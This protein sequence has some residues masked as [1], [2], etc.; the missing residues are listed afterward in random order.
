MTPEQFAREARRERAVLALTDPAGEADAVSPLSPA[1][2]WAILLELADE[3]AMR[4][5]V[6]A[7]QNVPRG[8]AHG[9]LDERI[10]LERL[11]CN[12]ARTHG[13]VRCPAHEDRT[14]SLSWRLDGDKALVHCMAG[15]RFGDIRAALAG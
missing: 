15:C 5:F 9:L 7:R 6:A 14:P 1:R 13:V 12:L 8:A 2:A 3:D 4:Q 10:L 11:G